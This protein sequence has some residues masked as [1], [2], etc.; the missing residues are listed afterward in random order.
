VIQGNFHRVKGAEAISS[1]GHHSDFVVQA[2]DGTAG[3]FAFGSKPVQQQLL[4]RAQ[5][6]CDF[7]HRL[8]AAAQGAPSPEVQEVAGV[9]DRFIGPEVFKEVLERA[10]GFQLGAEQSA[11]LTSGP[12][13]HPAVAP[14]QF[15][16]HVFE[17]LRLRP[18]RRAQAS[19]SRPPQ[20]G[21][22][23]DSN[24]R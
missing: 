14:Q 15:P 12:S 5:H 13:S 24:A 3:D 11:Q 19:R 18:A 2:L 1:S 9:L 16:A 8:N 20:P 23:P 7:F 6:A 17:M 4:M 21:P 22:A 10:R